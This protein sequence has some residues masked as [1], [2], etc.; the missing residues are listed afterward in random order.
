MNLDV[1]VRRYQS[2]FN[3]LRHATADAV[4]R[5]WVT[6]G[7]LTTTAEDRFSADAAQIVQGA[8]AAQILTTAAY[9]EALDDAVTGAGHPVVLDPD[10]FTDPRGVPTRD[11]YRRPI[12]QARAAIDR[13]H[14]F[15]EAM[16]QGRNRA[17][18]LAE[19]DISLVQSIATTAAVM[20]LPKIIGF[21]RVLTGSSCPICVGAEG[22]FGPAERMP[23]HAHCDCTSA[24]I[25]SS[26][27]PGAAVNASLAL[28]SGADAQVQEHG[29]LGPVLVD[30]DDEFT[31]F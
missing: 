1:A 22:R 4:S 6:H 24:P 19:T 11:V 14:D 30:G 16:A 17:S 9:Y 28:E 21:V 23:I 27:D 2:Q 18:S 26:V 25:Y 15:D 7:G 13:G 5:A 8:Q 29:E 31:D 20:Q 10:E 3:R 12:I